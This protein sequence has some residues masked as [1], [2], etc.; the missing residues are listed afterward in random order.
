MTEAVSDIKS[1]YKSGDFLKVKLVK[2]VEKIGCLSSII[3]KTA[4]LRQIGLMVQYFQFYDVKE[5]LIIFFIFEIFILVIHILH[6]DY[7]TTW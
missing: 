5:P 4:F 2:E 1:N 6:R 3:L 7:I